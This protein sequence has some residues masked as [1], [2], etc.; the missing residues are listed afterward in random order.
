MDTKLKS[1]HK[2]GIILMLAVVILPAVLTTLFYPVFYNKEKSNQIAEDYVA[3]LPESSLKTLY[4]GSYILYQDAMELMENKKYLPSDIFLSED[5]QNAAD[6][7]YNSIEDNLNQQIYEWRKSFQSKAG[8]LDYSVFNGD[9]KQILSNLTD[10]SL[11]TYLDPQSAA[12]EMLNSQKYAAVLVLGFNSVQGLKV[13]EYLDEKKIE[14]HDYEGELYS[15]HAGNLLAESAELHEYVY[16]VKS[17]SNITIVYAIEANSELIYSESVISG[18][19]SLYYTDEYRMWLLISLTVVGLAAIILPF[20]RPLGIGESKISQMPAEAAIMLVFVIMLGCNA[21]A[22]VIYQTCSGE[23]RDIVMHFVGRQVIADT[24]VMAFNV[25]IWSVIFGLWYSA[26]SSLRKI[27]VYGPWEYIKKHSYIYR[28]FP[29]LKKQLKRLYNYLTHFDLSDTS[30]KMIIK[31]VLVNF[32]AIFMISIFWAFGIFLAVI[33]SVILFFA[34][35]KYFED[36]K[37]KYQKMLDA[38]S[39]I[40]E[41]KFDVDIEDDLGM[42][43]SYKMQ[44]KKIRT[45]FK[46]AVDKEVRS[47][48]M[49]TELVTNVSHDLKTPLTAIITYINLLKDEKITEEERRSYIDTLDKKSMRLKALIE[50]L[51]EISKADS[52][53][54]SLNIVDVNLA[55][56]IR[57]VYFELSEKAEEAGLEFK[58]NLPEKAVLQ[59][60]SQKTYRIFENLLVNC[61]K[62]SLSGT[63][64]YVDMS[65]DAEGVSVEIKNIAA[66]EL[67][68]NT[69]DLTERFVR[70][71]MSRNTDGSG[72]GLAI[73]KSFTE[74]QGGSLEI[75][76]DGDLFKVR[77]HF[78]R[79]S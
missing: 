31:I 14:S 64:V 43:N 1:T 66:S 62:Y 50:D 33:Y 79:R 7:E 4:M 2:I 77:L 40:A 13:D 3:Y 17:P 59:L 68:L 70:G 69:P 15:L 76:V 56:L 10:G 46:K 54:V 5:I 26:I 51:F 19:A 49:K 18:P 8:Q 39:Q 42:F 58:I 47:H 60:D 11:D 37:C 25:A 75:N 36:I 20:I 74:I 16:S 21:A 12:A 30:N 38:T 22:S 52:G 9:G 78:N 53:N 57:Q 48:N 24:I 67:N 41:G 45:G 73:A 61:I 63:R 6:S 65:E 72:L 29:F 34:L 71:D 55:N 32:A 35:R 28:I 44:I 27:L 23:Y